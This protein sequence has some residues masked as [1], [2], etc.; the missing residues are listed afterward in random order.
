MGN[1]PEDSQKPD[2]YSLYGELIK[3]I[4][5]KRIKE[6]DVLKISFT[7]EQVD[8][9]FLS[10]G[11]SEDFLPSARDYAVDSGLL[12]RFPDRKYGMTEN[13]R[14]K[15]NLYLTLVLVSTIRPY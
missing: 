6:K 11:I 8:S 5:E 13:G 9:A 14:D 15:Y 12:T 10:L 7:E 4:K 3:E 2:L 1:E